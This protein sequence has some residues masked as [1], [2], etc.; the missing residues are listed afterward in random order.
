[1]NLYAHADKSEGLEVP[2]FSRQCKNKSE[3]KKMVVNHHWAFRVDY[4][5]FKNKR[6]EMKEVYTW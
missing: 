2:L 6:Y 4:V 1:M 3:A 5:I